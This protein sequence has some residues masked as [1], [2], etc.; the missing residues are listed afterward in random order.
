V[1][2]ASWDKIK[3]PDYDGLP[4]SISHNAVLKVVVGAISKNQDKKS[5]DSVR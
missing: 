4:D 2:I 1:D 3:K 5:G